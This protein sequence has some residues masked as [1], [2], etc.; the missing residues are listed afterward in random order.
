MLCSL[1]YFIIFYF[2]AL[3]KEGSSLEN[4]KRIQELTGILLGLLLENQ[5]CVD[6]TSVIN[7]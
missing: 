3:G 5:L 2:Y 4:K 7:Q 1:N 6:A